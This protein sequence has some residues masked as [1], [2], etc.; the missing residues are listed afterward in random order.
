MFGPKEELFIKLC[1][2][3]AGKTW[4]ELC[5]LYHNEILKQK[6]QSIKVENISYCIQD[7]KGET[8]LSY[9]SITTKGSV[10]K[11]LASNIKYENWRQVYEAGY[12]RVK[13]KIKTL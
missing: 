11:F 4:F 9:Y 7:S 2:E 6:S 12:R 13:I 3:N 5:A 1:K 8:K 10:E